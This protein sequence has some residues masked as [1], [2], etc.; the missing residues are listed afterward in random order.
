MK[1]FFLTILTILFVYSVSYG[2]EYLTGLPVNPVI[3]KHWEEKKAFKSSKL[4]YPTPVILPFFDDF[5]QKGIFPDTS[6]WLDNYV[7][8]NT[9]FPKF[10]PSIGAATFDAIDATGNIYPDANSLQ[11]YADQLTSKPIRLDSVFE[12]EPRA[13]TPAD[14]VYFS[15]FYQPQGRGNDP[16]KQDS[17]ILEFGVFT[18]D[19]VFW[20]IDSIEV[21][22]GTYINPGDTIFPGDILFSPCDSLWGTVMKDTLYA[23]DYVVLPCDSIYLPK[24]NWQKVWSSPGMTLD[25]FRLKND[26]AYFKQI[27]I[28]VT[29]EEFFRSNFQFRFYNFA[30][31]A[32]INLQSWQSN[33]DYWNVDYVY[34]NIDR[35]IGDTTYKDITF[36][37]RAPSFLKDYQYMPFYQYRNDPTSEMKSGIEILISNLDVINQTATY[38]YTVYNDV[39]NLEFDY[40]GGSWSLEPF[41]SYGYIDYQKFAYPP[42]EGIFPPFGNRDS[43]SFEIT[44]Y[45]E[46][47]PV[48][49]LGDTISY[50]QKFYNFYAY[51]DGTPEFGYGLTPAG[52]ELAYQFR[53]NKRDTLRAVQMFFNKTFSGVNDQFFH[54]IVW[55]DLNGRPGDIIYRQERER[56]VFEDSIYEYHTYYLDSIV[57]IQ[58]TF[59]VGCIQTTNDNLNIGFDAYNDASSHIFYNITGEWIKTSFEGSLMIRPVVG[60]QIHEYPVEKSSQ[61]T[62]FEVYPN[63]NYD[64][65]IRFKFS[66]LPSD[67]LSDNLQLELF[68]ILGQHVYSTKYHSQINL[69]FLPKG[70]Y[71]I[72]LIDNLNRKFYIRKIVLSR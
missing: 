13:L 30:S 63:P 10:P 64:G 65:L 6:R 27:M 4:V 14:S 22:V 47:D 36:I 29:N 72:K 15:F 32:S 71:I 3:K 45:L 17:L 11:F 60:K 58:G 24:S 34:L 48:L 70:V 51:D 40:T 16:Q 26:T 8:I 18:N 62:N 19:S 68:N 23:S 33:C 2:Q 52:A 42:V 54:L 69:T 28:P 39:G 31:I 7:Y 46:G 12:P 9:D 44:H 55:K 21:S 66:K 41:Y 35:N 57:P 25:S 61:I 67:E 49:K 37:E 59:Y 53:L 1:K 50:N 5:H 38:N 20:Y 56:P 43:A